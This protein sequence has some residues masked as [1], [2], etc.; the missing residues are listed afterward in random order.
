MYS[1]MDKR[2]VSE[3]SKSARRRDAFQIAAILI[4]ACGHGVQLPALTA[5]SRS[6]GVSEVFNLGHRHALVIGLH[7]AALR[8]GDTPPGALPI[9]IVFARTTGFNRRPSW[10]VE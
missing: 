9:L 7:L 8:A 1:A 3:Y 6:S 2:R 10:P 5:P 4:P